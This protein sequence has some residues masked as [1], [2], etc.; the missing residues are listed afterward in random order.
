MCAWTDAG[1]VVIDGQHTAIA[2]AT[3]GGFATIPC[4]VVEAAEAQ[5]QAS[6][7]VGHN[8]DRLT[9][10]PTQIHA[11]AARAG[12]ADALQIDQV[13]AAAG[14]AIVRNPYGAR[15]YKRGE[16]VAVG[17]I[18]S[19]IKARGQDQAAELLTILVSAGM[20]PIIKDHIRAV[21]ELLTNPEY[22]DALDP[23][24]LAAAIIRS[25]DTADKDAKLFAADHCAPFWRGLVNMWFRACRKRR[26]A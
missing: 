23:A 15:R 6:A 2:A 7:F 10:H 21:E 5:A 1:L 20:A 18:G 17:T 9:L 24:D 13:C 3:H 11:A 4:M 26:K 12:E 22:A 16:T 19:L 14:V 25:G 8:R